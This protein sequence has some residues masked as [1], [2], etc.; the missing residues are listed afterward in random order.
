M[1]LRKLV[2]VF[3]SISLAVGLCP[4]PAYAGEP[5]GLRAG[6]ISQSEQ[7]PPGS[8]G[9]SE[10]AQSPGLTAMGLK[11]QSGPSDTEG[12]WGFP[13]SDT[14]SYTY[15][16]EAHGLR[17]RFK[18]VESPATPGVDAAK[19][20]VTGIADVDEDRNARGDDAYGTVDCVIPGQFVYAYKDSLKD[21]YTQP[22]TV[23]QLG[24]A[25]ERFEPSLNIRSITIPATVN[26]VYRFSL[27]D[28]L[29]QIIF[30]PGSAIEEIPDDFLAYAN[31]ARLTSVA[32]PDTVARIGKNAFFNCYLLSDVNMPADLTVIGDKAF[33]NTSLE[34]LV[35]PSKLETIGYGA[36]A[37]KVGGYFSQDSAYVPIPGPRY[38]SVEIP[39]SVTA[40]GDFAFAGASP[41]STG[42]YTI[43]D[44][45]EYV[46]GGTRL[47]SVTFA[48]DARLIR[49]G[50]YAFAGASIL[51]LTLPSSLEFL[52]ADAGGVSHAFYD[53]SALKVVT[54]KETD[55][56]PSQL[57]VLG[58]FSNCTALEMVHMPHASVSEI[59]PSAFARCTALKSVSL[60]V[61]VELIGKEAFTDCDALT[62]V[63]VPG[64]V[65]EIGGRA[66][67]ACSN[68]AELTVE[69]GVDAIGVEAFRDCVKL[70][71]VTLAKGLKTIDDGAFS[72]CLALK[73]IEIPA[74]VS[75]IGKGAFNPRPSLGAYYP[76]QAG[77]LESLVIKPGFTELVID[78]GAFLGCVGLSGARA[79]KK[80]IVLPERVSKIGGGAFMYIQNAVFEIHNPNVVFAPGAGYLF[81][82]LPVGDARVF[83]DDEPDDEGLCSV[84]VPDPWQTDDWTNYKNL[85]YLNDHYDAVVRRDDY[86]TVRYPN[87]VGR[88][89]SPTFAV[90][91]EQVNALEDGYCAWRPKLEAVD[92]AALA[93][94]EMDDDEGVVDVAE[95]GRLRV[96][97]TGDAGSDAIVCAYD[98]SGDLV[99]SDQAGR[100]L[101][102]IEGLAAGTYTVT[103]FAKNANFSAVDSLDG[104]AALG[105]G[106]DDY[107]RR[108]GVV[109]EEDKDAVLE[110]PDALS[111]PRL[112]ATAT[113]TA[114]DYIVSSTL[115]VSKK[116]V[117]KGVQF[118]ATFNYKMKGGDKKAHR[119][120][121][122]VPQGMSLTSVASANKTYR[123]DETDDRTVSISLEGSDRDGGR[124][125]V[126]MKAKKT[127][128]FT[129][130]A[131]LAC[132]DGTTPGPTFPVGNATVTCS[133]LSLELPEG[134]VP[135]KVSG[136]T[137]ALCVD[138]F[139][140]GVYAAPDA[141]V[142]LQCAGTTQVVRTNRSGHAE[143]A[144]ALAELETALS[145]AY[146]VAS[147]NDDGVE[148]GAQGVVQLAAEQRD[149]YT[150]KD[151]SFVHAGKQYYIVKDTRSQSRS[152]YY[153]YVA[154]GKEANKHWSFEAVYIT[155]NPLWI[156]GRASSV[157]QNA[158]CTLQVQML[159]GS[160]RYEKMTLLGSEEQPDGSYLN[161]FAATLF[162]DQAGDHVFPTSLI[163]A[164]FGVSL[165]AP[166]SMS[167][168]LTDPDVESMRIRL[169]ETF[170]AW[171]VRVDNERKDAM[172]KK[173][174]DVYD[175]A[176]AVIDDA[177]SDPDGLL[178]GRT[179]NDFLDQD[180]ADILFYEKMR[181]W[182]YY[183]DAR[184][185]PD[186]YGLDADDRQILSDLMAGCDEAAGMLGSLYDA[187][188]GAET[189]ISE[190]G[191]FPEWVERNTGYTPDAQWNDSTPAQLE[192]AGWNV[193]SDA[194]ADAST[195]N[196]GTP[197]NGLTNPTYSE[198][199]AFATKTN[200]D[201]NGN[202]K[203]MSYRDSNGNSA[204]LKVPAKYDVSMF[205]KKD[206][207]DLI[208]GVFNWDNVKNGKIPRLD[209]RIEEALRDKL[210]IDPETFQKRYGSF[211]LS[212]Y[213]VGL[214]Y[215]LQG[216]MVAVDG[217]EQWQNSKELVEVFKD[218]DKARDYADNLTL[219]VNKMIKSGEWKENPDCFK[220]LKNE[221]DWAIIVADGLKTHAQFSEIEA[222]R[223]FGMSAG[224]GL[225]GATSG[226][227]GSVV[228]YGT[229][230]WSGKMVANEMNS[231]MG[232]LSPAQRNLAAAKLRRL[233]DCGEKNEDAP[234]D[235]PVI[236]DPSGVV[237][238]AWPGNPLEGVTATVYEGEKT[239]DEVT[240]WSEWD[241]AAYDQKNN[242]VTKADGAFSWDVPVGVW[243]VG[244]A[245]DGYE[246]AET[247]AMEVPP[248]RMGL[249]QPM[250]AVAGPAVKS[251]T[252]D[253]KSIEVTFDQYMD[254]TAVPT[255]DVNGASA[256][257]AWADVVEWTDEGAGVD[258]KFSKTLRVPAPAGTA[259]GSVLNLSID[260][261]NNYAGKG[262][263]AYSASITAAPRPTTMEFNFSETISMQA[264][265][266]RPAT[267]RIYDAAGNP[268]PGLE[269]TASLD[270]DNL[271]TVSAAGAVT[272]ATGAAKLQVEALLPGMS[273]LTVGVVG[274]ELARTVNLL[275]TADANQAE[276]PVAVVGSTTIG[277]GAPAENALT[278]DM[279]TKLQ[280]SCSTEGAVIYYTTD[281]SCPCQNT[282]GRKTYNGPIV[283]DESANYII[284][285]YK[286]G[287]DY[288][289]KLKL[290]L[291]V[292]RGESTIA[293]YDQKIPFTGSPVAY[294][295][296]I[297]RTGSTGAVSFAY[298]K[299]AACTRA[300]AA[301]AVKAVGT[302][303]VCATVAA[304]A[305]CK[306]ATSKPAKLVIVKAANTMKASGKSPKVKRSK[307]EKK[308]VTIKKASAF[309]ITAAQGKLTFKK[310]KGSKKV[311]VAKSGKVTVKKGL[312][313]GKY[314]V[315]VKVTAAGNGNYEKAVKTVT[316]TV[317]VR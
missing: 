24:M 40:I 199:K 204:T 108:D 226:P 297:D 154:N 58:G 246:S 99:A 143:A 131:S 128:T 1:K 123:T 260:G 300:V 261:A 163:P 170:G 169:H 283:L 288:S 306:S 174:P 80:I 200:K 86:V 23:S 316:M 219:R 147:V 153:T 158:S 214:G 6:T 41:V 51:M 269:L 234:Y 247:D 298:F 196:G 14:Q 215:A 186:D 238:E 207:S 228:M 211:N 50:D 107:A 149:P 263:A 181:I 201:A 290:S 47:T 236:L 60:P 189:S 106:D 150:L 20:A 83:T 104:Y 95:A 291:N 46:S 284:A 75:R 160:S 98:A 101:A 129:L 278:V 286:D 167:K 213:G 5:E 37:W 18:V 210:N 116:D 223:K 145:Y 49:I 313:K 119:L 188:L 195:G 294:Q 245:K 85:I 125:F 218:A 39:A 67:S 132:G 311:V 114:S 73:S 161:R 256:V 259:M 30:A 134:T 237:Y 312:K 54:F 216:G 194:N 187:L 250:V 124:I 118:F 241:A 314:K 135:A 115:A 82:E 109:I 240:S 287:M 310:V 239:G 231:N 271:A 279:G 81:A 8:L 57:E 45:L 138:P 276:R 110:G 242:Q 224:S 139:T 280:L 94:E 172:R 175:A 177:I 48:D 222:W 122:K 4:L 309:K 232:V 165:Y 273:E 9:A 63:T 253:D 97:T 274:A 22:I 272:D 70:D 11:A 79:D 78:D 265:T 156:G 315:R 15:D 137:G 21:D 244:F 62:S 112:Y 103:A 17:Y 113:V 317:I 31:A 34:S 264:G 100:G 229:D 33:Y 44:Q 121:L 141:D 190:C 296:R 202:V 77:G 71:S 178:G 61:S 59:A 304:D 55:A 151:F 270:N 217:Y 42:G 185:H 126:G 105:L 205:D 227:I 179:I 308:S 191:S 162:L 293:I 255:V 136:E 248:P 2:S 3:V 257:G 173:Y 52:G 152:S 13:A 65:A 220:A 225:A 176:G 28:R 305:R 19:V 155:D 102:I 184:D 90:Y 140:V 29:N 16:D 233:I 192:N 111:V 89:T 53:C 168:K 254:A 301:S 281:G 36:F 117:F 206:A 27:C 289:E 252:A 159:D 193:V 88:G 230:K 235:I 302:Y 144:I 267:V 182:E 307:L 292:V 35:L 208:S 76:L 12:R 295:G 277:A 7:E 148:V 203:S 120:V 142:I 285:S 127:G 68:L 249:E 282:P 212:K 56:N 64:S 87:T 243:K 303:Y 38:T 198:P 66:F 157:M 130:N 10:G 146:V 209:M 221:R 266:S 268:M 171:A 25:D 133:A 93:P 26:A 43:G 164:A 262:L 96:R 251:A 258:R 183:E 74:S 166:E 91:L 32:L 92:P 69:R 299:D 84:R 180:F 72:A 197:T 275:T